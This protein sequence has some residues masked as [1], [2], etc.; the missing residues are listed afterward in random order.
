MKEKKWIFFRVMVYLGLAVAI[1]ALSLLIYYAFTGYRSLRSVETIA[2]IF[3]VSLSIQIAF[4]ILNFRLIHNF[5]FNRIPPLVTFNIWHTILLA[6]NSCVAIALICLFIYGFL[7]TFKV[8][9]FRK[10][11]NTEDVLAL[12]MI[13]TYTFITIYTITG[14]FILKR[15]LK[16][17]TTLQEEEWLSQIGSPQINE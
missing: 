10:S 3:M 7:E 15:Y 11:P 14:S 6:L 9:P 1:M 4:N 5:L 2:L 16:H 17:C 12:A 13:G 8:N